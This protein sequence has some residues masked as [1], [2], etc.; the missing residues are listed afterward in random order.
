MKF[1]LP[2]RGAIMEHLP[3]NTL[4]KVLKNVLRQPLADRYPAKA[5]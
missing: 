5:S 1:K 3:R 2:K 4:S